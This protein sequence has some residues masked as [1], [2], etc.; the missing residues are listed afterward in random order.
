MKSYGKSNANE[1]CRENKEG[2]HDVVLHKL[3]K[4]K[5]TK[6]GLY[7]T[8][9]STVSASPV[10]LCSVDT[11]SRKD[12]LLCTC[13]LAIIYNNDTA[14][15]WTGLRQLYVRRSNTSQPAMAATQSYLLPCH[16][17]SV[18]DLCPQL[19]RDNNLN[20]GAINYLDGEWRVCHLSRAS[21]LLSNKARP[22]IEFSRNYTVHLWRGCSLKKS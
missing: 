16:T 9:T 18:H 6:K 14:P 3:E 10:P 19:S 21:S 20:M 15:H 7:N 12:H 2:L 5:A 1:F 4:T 11:I 17:D 22:V 13:S 8:G